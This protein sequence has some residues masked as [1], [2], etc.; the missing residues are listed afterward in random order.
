MILSEFAEVR[1]NSNNVKRYESLGY[2]IP[3]K[4]A[5][6]STRSH[7][8]R[9]WVY[10]FSKTIMVNVKDLPSGSPA[11]VEILCDMCKENKMIVAY[12]TYNRVVKKT[13]SYVCQKCS[14]EKMERTMEERYGVKHAL[15]S[16]CFLNAFKNTCEERY[17]D[18]YGKLFAEKAF[19]SF[20][21]NTGY[22]YPSQSP[23]MRDKTK[24]TC[25]SKYGYENAAQSPEVRQKMVQTLYANSSQKASTQQRYICNLYQGVLNYPVK[26]YNVDIYLPEDSLTI[27]Y[28]G[29]FHLGNVIT[30]RET[31]EEHNRKEIIRDKTIKSE[32]YK[33]MRIISANDLLPSDQ[34]LF[35][36][37]SEARQYFSQYPNHSW[38]EFN[39]DTSTVRNAEHRNGA[40]FDFGELRKISKPLQSEVA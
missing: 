28:D 5:A 8:G 36:M 2:E 7:T 35:Q 14:R 4:K 31:E 13:G 30:G 3:V 10:D 1:V 12:D 19:E 29:G 9:E 6:K 38:I 16:E 23:E 20:Y 33:Q 32:G 40:F 24:Q 37:L 17:G 25:V 11:K 39:I 26:Y 15:Q 22:H 34:I 27:E 21:E 18:D